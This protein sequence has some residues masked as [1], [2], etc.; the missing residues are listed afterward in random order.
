MELRTNVRHLNNKI[1]DSG[2]DSSGKPKL[3]QAKHISVQT[4][5]I[6]DEEFLFAGASGSGI[7]RVCI[8]LH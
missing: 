7:V 6:K 2:C 1:K 5:E 3:L 8:L 4:D